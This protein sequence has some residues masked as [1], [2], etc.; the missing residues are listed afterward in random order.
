M[1]EKIERTKKPVTTTLIILLLITIA[2]AFSTSN[3]FG[4]ADII[5][6]YLM[7]PL[8][9][10]STIS[11]VYW[12]LLTDDFWLIYEKSDLALSTKVKTILRFL[13]WIPAMGLY[14]FA[15]T[16]AALSIYN[17]TFSDKTPT[18]IIGQVIHKDKYRSNGTTRYYFEIN[19]L[20]LRRKIKLRVDETEYE[21]SITGGQFHTERNIGAL[22]II[23]ESK[24]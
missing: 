12:L 24:W 5:L 21:K 14:F 9:I 19:D 13:I 15:V 16:Q 23:Y 20:K 11:S 3:E 17:R 8:I 2:D 6:G 4:L 1:Q 22:G 7:I 10:L 18:L